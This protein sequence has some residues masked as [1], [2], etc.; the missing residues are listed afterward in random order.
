[1]SD[2]KVADM[3]PAERERYRA[4]KRRNKALYKLRHPERIKAQSKAYYAKNQEV[5]KR[6]SRMYWAN[7]LTREIKRK[8]DAAYAAA[9]R[10]K[11]AARD[12]VYARAHSATITA[13][14]REWATAHPER[15]L[16]Y[17]QA[18]RDRGS[19]GY[20]RKLLT[21][22]NKLCASGVSNEVVALKRE[23]LL[24]TRVIRRAKKEI[25]NGSQ[26]Q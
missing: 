1:M 10:E 8:R 15:V 6:A 25:Q 14:A 17:R 20:I 23:H 26:N 22:G 7:P 9:N 19:N 2:K 5:L 11:I 21:E 13:R 18:A 24:L 4:R 3:T 16:A 12:R